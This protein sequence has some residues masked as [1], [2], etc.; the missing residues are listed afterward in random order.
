MISAEYNN[1]SQSWGSLTKKQA[2]SKQSKLPSVGGI[3]DSIRCSI[4]V[5]IL[6]RDPRG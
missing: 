3:Q 6:K 5:N 1:E 2:I 4:G